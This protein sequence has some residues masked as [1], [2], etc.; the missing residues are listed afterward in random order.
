MD[1]VTVG[2]IVVYALTAEDVAAIEVYRAKCKHVDHRTDYTLARCAE[3][4]PVHASQMFPLLVTAVYSPNMVNGQV[5]L[6]GNDTLWVKHCE[7]DERAELYPHEG[8]WIWPV[9]T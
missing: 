2:R 1:E 6:D 9:R 4:N 3:G 5:F 8:K 7:F